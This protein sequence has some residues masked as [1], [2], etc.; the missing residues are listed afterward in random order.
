MVFELL[1]AKQRAR[2]QQAEH[3]EVVCAIRSAAEAST[4][5]RFGLAKL[6]RGSITFWE[7]GRGSVVVPGRDPAVFRVNEVSAP[8]SA[9]P[10]PRA[11]EFLGRPKTRVL[12]IT[13]PDGDFELAVPNR[14]LARAVRDLRP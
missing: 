4:D 8:D 12:R 6:A 3:G 5:W 2:L 13:S 9:R 10:G 14:D 7:G 11:V 1:W